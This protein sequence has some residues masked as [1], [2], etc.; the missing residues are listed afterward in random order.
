MRGMRAGRFGKAALVTAIVSVA[1]AAGDYTET[2]NKVATAIGM[3]TRWLP[4]IY[5]GLFGLALWLMRMEYE[6]ADFDF[7]DDPLTGYALEC[8]EQELGAAETYRVS[9][10]NYGRTPITA[11]VEL[12]DISPCPA[13]LTGQ[14]G[15]PLV[16]MGEP[17]SSQPVLI[18]PGDRKAFNLVTFHRKGPAAMLRL[19]HEWG[20]ASQDL[21]WTTAQ[22]STVSAYSLVRAIDYEFLLA[23][24]AP[25][26]G[27]KLAKYR[28]EQI[29]DHAL[30]PPSHRLLRVR[31]PSRFRRALSSTPP[32]RA[33]SSP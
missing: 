28:L 13:E 27:V 5:I 16:R 19:W 11:S 30:F 32:A 20:R 24:T 25:E 8:D 6:S 26:G 7:D 31:K 21:P 15:M 29:R 9:V 10:H 12:R 4:L 17:R 1:L 23:V 14:L 22:D 18:A 2:A 3:P 33:T